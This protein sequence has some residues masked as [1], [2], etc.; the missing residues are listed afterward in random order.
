M[1]YKIYPDKHLL[2][3]VMEGNIDITDLEKIFH[4]EILNAD[5][6]YVEKILSNISNA[7]PNISANDIQKFANLMVSF[8]SNSLLRW[9]ILTEKPI[10]AALSFLIKENEFF[11]NIVGVYSTLEACNQFLNIS[12]DM[13]CFYEEDYLVLE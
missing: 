1:K 5:F 7:H 8:G 9:A 2:V 6:K 13:K 4:H 12:F 10:Q 11:S 3:D